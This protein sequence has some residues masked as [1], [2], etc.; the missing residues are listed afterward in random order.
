MGK[1][2]RPKRLALRRAQCLKITMSHFVYI[3]I[4]NQK[5]FYVGSTDNIERRVKEE[6]IKVKITCSSAMDPSG[7]FF[8]EVEIKCPTHG[9]ITKLNWL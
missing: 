5:T 4:C 1:Y 7:G 9:I 8:T 2:M 6:Y 3:L